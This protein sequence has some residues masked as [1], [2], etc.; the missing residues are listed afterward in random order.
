MT[1]FMFKST[2]YTFLPVQH[3]SRAEVSIVI[4]LNI[5]LKT[6]NRYLKTI[7]STRAEDAKKFF[8]IVLRQRRSQ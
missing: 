3:V 4:K 1:A 8:R 6:E 7:P 2:F 5:Q